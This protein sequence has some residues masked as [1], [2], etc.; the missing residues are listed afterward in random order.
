ML[1]DAIVRCGL[2]S[3]VLPPLRCA[4]LS[5]LPVSHDSLAGQRLCGSTEFTLH[6]NQGED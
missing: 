6:T 3:Q 2:L 1:I 5:R 4:S